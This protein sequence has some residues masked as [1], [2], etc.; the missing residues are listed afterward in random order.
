[1]VAL[2]SYVAFNHATH[3]G[4]NRHG[5]VCAVMLNPAELSIDHEAQMFPGVCTACWLLMHRCAAV[6][7]HTQACH[8]KKR[9]RKLVMH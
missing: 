8:I 2:V 5:L 4:Q 6:L 3:G 9:N 7:A 1:L